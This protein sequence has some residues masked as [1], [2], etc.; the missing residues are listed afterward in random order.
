MAS[1]I[2]PF[3]NNHPSLSNATTRENDSG[4]DNT[5]TPPNP[6]ERSTSDVAR[7]VLF[8][9]PSSQE[10]KGQVPIVTKEI[11]RIGLNQDGPGE[12]PKKTCGAIAKKVSAEAEKLLSART[13]LSSKDGP[14]LLGNPNTSPDKDEEKSLEKV[15]KTAK[16]FEAHLDQK[17]SSKV[18]K[19]PVSEEEGKEN[20]RSNTSTATTKKKEKP[21]TFSTYNRPVPP[22]QHCSNFTHTGI[23]CLLK[24]LEELEIN[25]NDGNQIKLFR[26]DW[27][28]SDGHLRGIKPEHLKKMEAVSWGYRSLSGEYLL[29]ITI[30]SIRQDTDTGE[31]KNGVLT[32]FQMPVDHFFTRFRF[33]G[34]SAPIEILIEKDLNNDNIEKYLGPLFNKKVLTLGKYKFQLAEDSSKDSAEK[35]S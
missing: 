34:R 6:V 23:E 4:S 20:P 21:L 5:T 11:E 28:D 14:T 13:Q 3:T 8:Q 33:A 25:L 2:P 16:F 9:S 22:F 30:K 27:E 17:E 24:V 29:Y 19:A 35:P 18:Q 1:K 31:K 12:T 10:I 26:S 32:I 7:T 15:D